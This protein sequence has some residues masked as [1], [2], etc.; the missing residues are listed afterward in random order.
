[1]PES[2]PENKEFKRN[3]FAFSCG[4]RSCLGR[5]L[6]WMEMMTILANIVKDYNPCVPEKKTRL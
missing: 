4:P 3:I 6:A 1:M 2:S 5:G